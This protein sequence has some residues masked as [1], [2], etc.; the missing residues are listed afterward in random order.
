MIRLPKDLETKLREKASGALYGLS[1]CVIDTI[2]DS[3]DF[4]HTIRVIGH[5]PDD[6]PLIAKLYEIAYSDDSKKLMAK[7]DIDKFSVRYTC[8]YDDYNHH[9]YI[10]IEVDT[11][12]SPIHPMFLGVELED[13]LDLENVSLGCGRQALLFEPEFRERFLH[14]IQDYDLECADDDITME[15]I[16]ND[17]RAKRAAFSSLHELAS[18]YGLYFHVDLFADARVTFNTYE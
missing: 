15:F 17:D 5:L 4:L 14:Y 2:L 8:V 18:K 10:I 12:Y 16:R 1:D 6:H 3:A 11:R 9:A 7:C 13:Y